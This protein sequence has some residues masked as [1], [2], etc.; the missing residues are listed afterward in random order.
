MLFIKL[1]DSP[2]PLVFAVILHPTVSWLL[3]KPIA[4]SAQTDEGAA[5]AGCAAPWGG[6]QGTNQ[7][8]DLLRWPHPNVLGGDEQRQAGDSDWVLTP[9]CSPGWGRGCLGG[10][11]RMRLLTAPSHS[12]AVFTEVGSVSGQTVSQAPVGLSEGAE[13]YCRGG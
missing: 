3:R 12:L 9:Y 11:Q 8:R 2:S 6:E 4:L 13:E 7:C 5:R 1:I 10:G